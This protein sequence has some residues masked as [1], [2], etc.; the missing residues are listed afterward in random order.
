M[1]LVSMT[2]QKGKTSSLVFM[3]T[4]LGRTAAGWRR[5]IPLFALLWF[6]SNPFLPLIAERGTQKSHCALILQLLC[7][8]SESNQ[9][10]E[11][12]VPRAMELLCG[13]Q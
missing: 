6:Q 13:G 11:P 5:E 7:H 12:R 4:R 10:K 1:C 9:F 2:V 8:V 3:E